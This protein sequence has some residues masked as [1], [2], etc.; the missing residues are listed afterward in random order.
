MTHIVKLRWVTPDAEKQLI[1]IAKISNPAKRDEP[2][3]NLIGYLI[4][5]KHWSPFEMVNLCF[6]VD[7]TRDIGRQLIRH[8][9]MGVQEFSQRYADVSA[10][11]DPVFRECRMQDPTNRQNSVPCEDVELAE[12]WGYAQAH[13]WRK[14]WDHYQLALKQGIAKEVARVLLPEGM[15]P[16]NL[17]FNANLRSALHFCQVR[18]PHDGAQKEATQVAA[19]VEAIIREHFPATWEA[20]CDHA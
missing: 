14:A 8:K 3:P 12:W 5:H 13:V 1:E 19:G 2:S 20:W 15:T 6:D 10:L 9:S 16:S 11:G 7:T 18:G 4:K 17:T